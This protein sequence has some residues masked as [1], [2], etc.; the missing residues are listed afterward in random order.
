MIDENEELISLDVES[1]HIDLPVDEAI[2][3]TAE[4]LYCTSSPDLERNKFAK[5]MKI[6]TK[7]VKLKVVVHTWFEQ[8]DG[9][10]IGSK[11]AVYLAN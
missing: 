11:L 2:A 10:V 4:K 5:M 6:F 7:N 3:L 1:L 8:I 9:L